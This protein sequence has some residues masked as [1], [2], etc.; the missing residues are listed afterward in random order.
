MKPGDA[1]QGFGIF[2]RLGISDDK[3]NA[4]HGFYSFGFGG[5][6]MLTGREK[7]QFGIGYYYLDI[8]NKLTAIVRQRLLRGHDQ[9][10]ELYYNFAVAPWLH[11]TPDLQIVD[12]A[13]RGTS[14]AVVDGLRVKVDF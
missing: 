12:P 4:F 6:G 13:V 8:S 11:V 5:K 2:G 14:I 10:V 1:S 7:D 3:A 9:G